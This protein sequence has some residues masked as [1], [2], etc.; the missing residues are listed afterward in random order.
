MSEALRSPTGTAVGFPVSSAK[1]LKAVLAARL[2]E[3]QKILANKACA[4]G[5]NGLTDFDW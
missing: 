5:G 2:E 1:V 3:T 4:I